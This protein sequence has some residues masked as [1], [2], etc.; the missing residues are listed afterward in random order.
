[1]LARL[2]AGTIFFRQVEGSIQAMVGEGEIV[3]SR[4]TGAVLARAN[5][6]T[7][8][9][10][11][12]GGPSDLKTANGSIEVLLAKGA[13][14]AFAEAGDVTVNF[15]RGLAESS[16]LATSGGNLAV[17]VDPAANCEVDASAIWGRVRNSLPLTGGDRDKSGRRLTGT[18]NAG[19]PRL[20]LQANGGSVSIGP[21]ETLFE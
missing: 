11:T 5:R 7:I 4:C 18:L 12:I 21:G 9:L 8:R 17:T 14:T 19:G 3:I 1:M 13:L 15:P 2:D 10:G 6:G 20:T 16:N